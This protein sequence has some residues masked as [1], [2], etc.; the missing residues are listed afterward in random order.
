MRIRIAVIVLL[1]FLIASTV[2]FTI[3][4]TNK[5]SQIVNLETL[6]EQQQSEIDELEQQISNLQDSE[7]ANLIRQIAEKDAQIAN[8][9]VQNDALSNQISDLQAQLIY[10]KTLELS[11]QEKIRDSAIDYIKFNHPET[12]QF[13]NEL[14]WMGGRTTPAILV[15][16]ETYVYK[17]SGWTFTINFAA[18]SNPLYNL[19]ADYSA[20]FTGIPYR[21]IWN[22]SWQNWCITEHSYIFAQ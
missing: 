9:S 4:L 14:D 3:F 18:G 17:S 13:M 22:G 15:S 1:I 6:T 10:N 21:V 8:L 20:P 7:T 5:D 2:S 19:T 11:I 16:E 12:A